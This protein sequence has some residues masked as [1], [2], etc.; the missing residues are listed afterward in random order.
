MTSTETDF[1]STSGLAY[2]ANSPK[3]SVSVRNSLANVGARYG[4]KWCVCKQI[5]QKGNQ[6]V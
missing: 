6:F 2:Y 1:D 3:S 4:D 5:T